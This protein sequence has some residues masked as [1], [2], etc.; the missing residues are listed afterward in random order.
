MD[1]G[2]IV[3]ELLLLGDVGVALF[4][5]SGMFRVYDKYLSEKGTSNTIS[6]FDQVHHWRFVSP[7][8]FER[9]VRRIL[10]LFIQNNLTE[11][12][13]LRTGCENHKPYFV[14][15]SS[16][17]LWRT[18]W[19]AGLQAVLLIH[20]GRALPRKVNGKLSSHSNSFPFHCFLKNPKCHGSLN[21]P[22][23]AG[24]LY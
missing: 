11:P 18:E 9:G 4:T 7:I 21:F 6:L 15:I 24:I 22:Q 17:I 1:S 13:A 23:L 14:I 10:D 19:P 16:G 12:L 5:A 3:P 20:N 8:K 2:E